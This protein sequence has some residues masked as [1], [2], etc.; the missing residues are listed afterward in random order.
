MASSHNFKSHISSH[1][2]VSFIIFI[3]SM[4]KHHST[5]R[6]TTMFRVDPLLWQP[7]CPAAW[8]LPLQIDTHLINILRSPFDHVWGH[9]P[10]VLVFLSWL[11]SATSYCVISKARSTVNDIIHRDAD[12]VIR[13][14]NRVISFPTA[15]KLHSISAG[16]LTEPA[17]SGFVNAW[18][19]LWF[20]PC[21]WLPAHPV[22]HI[23][24]DG[25]NI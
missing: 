16:H 7:K 20:T 19:L 9:D 11:A 4:A 17:L 6:W 15:D 8:L 23:I 3:Y 25:V 12:K 13:L 14:T 21:H 18:L 24:N 2:A 5:V 22:S 10:V 1:S